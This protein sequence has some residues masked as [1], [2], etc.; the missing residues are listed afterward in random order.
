[1]EAVTVRKLHLLSLLAICVV[2]ATTACTRT[3]QERRFPEDGS[4]VGASESTIPAEGDAREDS[5]ETVIRVLHEDHPLEYG[6]PA[7]EEFF[8]PADEIQT[9]EESRMPSSRTSSDASAGRATPEGKSSRLSNI[10]ELLQYIKFTSL[11]GYRS[12]QKFLVTHPKWLSMGFRS[13]ERGNVS[14]VRLIP[15]GSLETLVIGNLRAVFGEGLLLGRRD[16]HMTP[17][18]A[19]HREGNLRFSS[20]LSCWER[21]TG[22]G[23]GVR[24]GNVR[25]GALVWEREE[26]TAAPRQRE[27]WLGAS[28]A[29]NGWWAGV[30][31]GHYLHPSHPPAMPRVPLRA[32]AVSFRVRQES[33]KTAST[34]HRRTGISGEVAAWDDE[35][36]YVFAAGLRGQG[37]GWIRVF[38]QPAAE[39]FGGSANGLSRVSRILQG[40]VLRWRGRAGRAKIELSL[41][42]GSTSGSAKFSRYRRG[43]IYVG[44]RLRRIHSHAWGISASLIER[45]KQSFASDEL[46]TEPRSDKWVEERLG[47]QW[48]FAAGMNLSHRLRAELRFAE[49]GGGTGVVISSGGRFSSPWGEIV[50]RFTNYRLVATMCGFVSRPGVGPFEHMSFVYGGGSDVSLRVKLWICSWFEI[51]AY[52]GRPWEKP[53]RMYIGLAY[54]R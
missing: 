45:R 3:V 38:R 54:P 40:G 24:T 7:V 34:P 35:V 4:T 17:L 37:T 44:E 14:F 48:D 51:L 31:T 8:S 46:E 49:P 13:S 33:A 50:Y 6:D 18:C 25:F 12:D 36:F 5:L 15:P 27:L 19:T 9:E 21:T 52:Y 39:G 16:P 41:Y 53:G 11:Y 30:V 43:T 23:S 29:R 47:L 1:M 10:K 28:L 2:A 26:A 42:D 20:S 22:V 32:L